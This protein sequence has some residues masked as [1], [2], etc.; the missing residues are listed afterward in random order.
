[1]RLENLIK[2]YENLE[3]KKYKIVKTPRI[4]IGKHIESK[5]WPLRFFIASNPF[6]SKGKYF[7]VPK[8]IPSDWGKE[9]I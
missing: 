9:E 6:V 2:I 8:N 3:D 7:I 5:H 4:G 1:M